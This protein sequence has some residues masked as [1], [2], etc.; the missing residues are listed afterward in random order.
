MG[1]RKQALAEFQTRRAN[2]L[3]EQKRQEKVRAKEAFV[4]LLTEVL[5]NV[6]AFHG[7]GS[8]GGGGGNDT[9]FGEVRDSLSK[10]DRFYAVEEEGKRE[11]LFYDFV[12][13]LRKREERQRRGRKR[14]A[15]EA[16]V[17]F[18]KLKEDGGNLTFASTWTSFLGS[19]EE[20]DKGDKRFIVSSA[21]SDSDR[22]LYFADFVI[23]LQAMEDE[24]RRRIRDARRSAEKAQRDAYRDTLRSMATQGKIIPSSRW[25][26][27]EDM[28]SLE[29]TFGPVS[30]Q[31][32]DAPRDMF[33]DFVDD[34]ADSYR[35]DKV[36]LSRLF[37]TFKTLIVTVDT[38]YGEFTKALLEEAAYSPDVYSDA[39]R[40]LNREE[41]LTSAKLFFNELVLQ[42]KK[43]GQSSTSFGR[44]RGGAG[45]RDD[46]SADE[47][48]IVEDGEVEEDTTETAVQQELT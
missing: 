6:R 27:F 45:N 28:L 25:R 17:V 46:S 11:E 38:Q 29:G 14:D 9:G 21:M 40:V 44:R 24:K 12:E 8:G 1:E 39:R 5:P 33:E 13:E 34:W 10:D 43:D 7:K 3:R 20:N 26:N 23:E 35:R 15:K 16:F 36:F 32:R 37:S 30:E 4:S 47:G 18:L 2:E 48:E 42:A 41:P 22:Q 19:L 31:D